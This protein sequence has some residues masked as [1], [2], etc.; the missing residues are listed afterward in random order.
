MGGQKK[1]VRFDNVIG[2]WGKNSL[3]CG[4]YLYTYIQMMNRKINDLLDIELRLFCYYFFGN[5]PL[6]VD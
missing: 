5:M 6:D 2:L 1:K 4:I 3:K